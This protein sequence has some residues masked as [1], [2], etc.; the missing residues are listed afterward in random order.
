MRIKICGITQ[1]DQGREIASLGAT[2]I[3]SICFAKSPRYVS[4]LIMAQIVRDLPTNVDKIGVFVNSSAET[5]SHIVQTTHLTGVQLHGEEPPEFCQQ[6]KRILPSE[7]ELIKALRIQNL[8]SL[9]A[10]EPYQ[11]QVDTLLLDAYHPNL[12]GGSGQTIDW[13]ILLKFRPAIPWLLAGGLN[14]DNVK[15]AIA[16]LKPDGID[17]SSGVE[18]APGDKDLDLVA[19]LFDNL[20]FKR[21]LVDGE[22]N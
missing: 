2:A 10:S 4:P 20:G 8:D 15:S 13:E 6:L 18:R 11:K 9:R 17:L 1:P 7:I 21:N 22:S 12:R 16:T 5:I 14:P 3:G 19:R